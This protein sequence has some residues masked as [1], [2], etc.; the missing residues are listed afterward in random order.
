MAWVRS[1]RFDSETRAA[2]SLGCGRSISMSLPFMQLQ[3]ALKGAPMGSDTALPPSTHLLREA[4][5][6]RGRP[7]CALLQRPLFA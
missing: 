7:L 5:Q 3:R 2:A 1:F 4:A 6:A